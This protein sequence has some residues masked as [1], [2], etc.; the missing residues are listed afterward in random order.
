MG[1]ALLI[2]SG[3]GAKAKAISWIERAP[4]NTRVEFKGPAR[5]LPQNSRMW[6]MLSDFATQVEHGG[7]K[8]DAGS[9][10]EI[11]MHALGKETTFVPNLDGTGFVPLGLRSS[12]LSKQE[13]SDLIELLFAEGAR[14]GVQWSDPT[15]E[16]A[17]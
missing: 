11:F 10:K 12:D 9:W 5:S 7:R 1:R 13:M 14:R 3:Q 2:L 4:W 17:A 16:Q 6:A 8:Y 15:Q